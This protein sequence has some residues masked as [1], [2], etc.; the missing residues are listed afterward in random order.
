MSFIRYRILER[1]LIKI[2]PSPIDRH[3]CN[4]LSD[5][6]QRSAN[7][8]VVKFCFNLFAPTLMHH[9]LKLEYALYE[10][11]SF[12]YNNVQLWR[13]QMILDDI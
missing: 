8:S 2:G 4:V 13:S 3:V 1:S 7:S 11:F 12:I 10:R 9:P 5:R 6:F